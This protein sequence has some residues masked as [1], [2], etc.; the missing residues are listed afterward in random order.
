VMTV[1][2]AKKA[3]VVFI[4]NLQLFCKRAQRSRLPGG[5]WVNRSSSCG[6]V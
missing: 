2:I 1:A 5:K 6:D 4:E 3:E